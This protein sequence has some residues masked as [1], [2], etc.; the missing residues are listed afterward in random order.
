VHD[1]PLCAE[2]EKSAVDWFRPSTT[3]GSARGREGGLTAEA[4][5]QAFDRG[6]CARGE[7]APA[8]DSR[9]AT[10]CGPSEAQ[11]AAAHERVSNT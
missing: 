9:S 11:L 7:R 8:E 2:S 10:R 6:Y 3:G 1:E 5:S 4:G